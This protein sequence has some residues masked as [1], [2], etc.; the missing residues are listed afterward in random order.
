MSEASIC[1]GQNIRFRAM[2][3]MRGHRNYETVG[4]WEKSEGRAARRMFTKFLSSNLYKR[5]EVWVVADYYDP[6]PTMEIVR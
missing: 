1:G 4:P 5:G 2:V 6:T 3:R